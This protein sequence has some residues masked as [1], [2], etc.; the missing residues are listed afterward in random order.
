M[1]MVVVIINSAMHAGN[2]QRFMFEISTITSDFDTL[3]N[4]IRYEKAMSC[5]FFIR[6]IHLRNV[7]CCSQSSFQMACW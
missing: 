6:Q 3:R 7:F 5:D 2:L 4:K 1:N